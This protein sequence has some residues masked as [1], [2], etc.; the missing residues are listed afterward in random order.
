MKP[1]EAI[2]NALT[3][4]GD[5]NGFALAQLLRQSFRLTNRQAWKFI[6]TQK[7]TQN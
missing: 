5:L 3:L 7:H 1:D 2:R 6:L 4:Y